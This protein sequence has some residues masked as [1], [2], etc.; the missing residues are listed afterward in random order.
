LFEL[1]I[2][3]FQAVS[4]NFT[5]FT[6]NYQFVVGLPCKIV[7]N[8]FQGFRR[9]YI[10]PANATVVQNAVVEQRKSRAFMNAKCRRDVACRVSTIIK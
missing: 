1:Y 4:A 3:I 2:F 10:A 6:V 5:P 8:D 9:Q 7:F